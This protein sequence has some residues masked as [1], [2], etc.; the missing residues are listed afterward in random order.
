MLLNG[1]KF[2]IARDEDGLLYLYMKKPYLIT[3][4][5]YF[6]NEYLIGEIDK[7]LFPEVTFKNSPK[8]VELKLVKEEEI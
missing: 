5:H 6:D 8:E 2:W 3:H 1:M 7:D 4:T